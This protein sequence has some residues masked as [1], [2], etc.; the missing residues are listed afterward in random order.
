M[1]KKIVD[2]DTL[3][4]QKITNKLLEDHTVSQIKTLNGCIGNC[5]K[6]A[7]A[8]NK[9]KKQSNRRNILP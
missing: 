3:Y 8:I 4:L 1:I 2:I 6:Y 9:L 5:I 7:I